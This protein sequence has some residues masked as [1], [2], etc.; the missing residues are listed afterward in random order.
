ME[1]ETAPFAGR[2]PAAGIFLFSSVPSLFP[3]GSEF[4]LVSFCSRPFGGCVPRSPP[5]PGALLLRVSELVGSASDLNVLALF[6][7][8]SLRVWR[9]E[10]G[11]RRVHGKAT[12]SRRLAQY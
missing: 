1:Q 9:Q 7:W 2:A 4:G 11:R 8:G 3:G 6:P 5:P 12:F 10:V